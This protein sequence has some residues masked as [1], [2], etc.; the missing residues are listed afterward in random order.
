MPNGAMIVKDEL[1]RMC[2]KP[3][4]ACFKVVKNKVKAVPVFCLVLCD[5]DESCA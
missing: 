4:V 1:G 5:G 2:K 3:I